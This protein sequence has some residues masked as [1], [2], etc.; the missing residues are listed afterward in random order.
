MNESDSA[1][2][3]LQ[4]SFVV[5]RFR[6]LFVQVLLFLECFCLALGATATEADKTPAVEFDCVI[7]PS[8]I[9]NLGT[10]VRGV[11]G[12][13]HAERSD[14][15]AKGELVAVLESSV[16][17]ANVSLSKARAGHD[18]AVKLRLESAAFGQR[19]RARNQS[20]FQSSSVSKQDID[21]LETENRIAEL[22]VHQEQDNRDIA[23]LEYERAQALLDKHM[24]RAPFAG[25]VM[26]RFKSVGEYIEDDPVFRIAQLDPLNVEVI[27]PVSYMGQFEPGRQAQVTP[28]L[29]GLSG[30]VATLTRVDQ[31]ADAASSTFGA[32]LRLPNPDHAVPAGLRCRLAFLPPSAAAE[33]SEAALPLSPI[34]QPRVTPVLPATVANADLLDNNVARRPHAQECYRVGPFAT[35]SSAVALLDL[36]VKLDL[37]SPRHVDIETEHQHTEY[38]VLAA[39]EPDEQPFGELE[40]YLTDNG[41]ED[42]YRIR[43][44]EHYGRLSLGFFN[45]K[46]NALQRQAEIAKLG[47]AADVLDVSRQSPAWWTSVA[48][49]SDADVQVLLAS[50]VMAIAPKALV[51]HAEC[52][53]TNLL[54]SVQDEQLDSK[55]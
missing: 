23:L 31:V 2:V 36:M 11:I 35:E 16:E 41:E 44:A 55:Q 38:L 28:M 53:Q 18:T 37:S 13:I 25:V 20:L 39:G 12:S 4:R 46:D 10:A 26:E 51:Q 52:E 43:S 33:G 32:R 29:E 54:L 14:S 22:Q 34:A 40:R 45:V 49:N 9:V 42:F 47:V 8:E 30:Q 19:T 27:L 3:R 6:L 17:N 24:I 50:T 7:E 48:I 15:V 5:R 21:K 1:I